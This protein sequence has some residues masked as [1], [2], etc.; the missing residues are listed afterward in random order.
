LKK[1]D[2]KKA[3]CAALASIA[4]GQEECRE[5]IRSQP[6]CRAVLNTIRKQLAAPSFDARMAL[7]WGISRTGCEAKICFNH[8][9]R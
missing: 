3:A 2:P 6:L 4:N 5:R 8:S 9:T 7:F 1:V